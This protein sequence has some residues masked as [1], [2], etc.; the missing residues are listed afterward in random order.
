[1]VATLG[2]NVLAARIRLNISAVET[3]LGR[4]TQRISS[5]YKLPLEAPSSFAVGALFESQARSL[6][7][8]SGNIQ[9]GVSMLDVASAALEEISD[10]LA[11]MAS[12]AVTASDG[13]LTDAQRLPLDAEFQQNKTAINSLVNVAFYNGRALLNGTGGTV[14]VQVGVDSGQTVSISFTTNYLTTAP[15]AASATAPLAD[16]N[17]AG[18]APSLTT[19]ANATAALPLVTTA[20]DLLGEARANTLGP[21]AALDAIAAMNGV[22]KI[23]ALEGQSTFV[24]ADVAADTTRLVRDQL[25]LSAGASALQVANFSAAAVVGLLSAVATRAAAV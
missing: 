8:A 18:A 7:A 9:G 23:A 13:T 14:T 20:Q 3:D 10:L 25:L 11:N 15:G 5:G 16:L 24:S 17:A 22:A 4:V 2:T 6:Q 21:G 1:M 19:Q 12:L